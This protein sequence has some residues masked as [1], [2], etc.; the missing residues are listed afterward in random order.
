MTYYM[1]C[2][3]TDPYT[4]LQTALLL[5]TTC[6]INKHNISTYNPPQPSAQQASLSLGSRLVTSPP[7]PPT[8]CASAKLT[9]SQ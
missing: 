4:Q 3:C 2:C 1:F 5:H 7:P 8:P 6:L 9:S